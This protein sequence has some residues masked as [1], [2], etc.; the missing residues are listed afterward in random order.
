VKPATT[1]PSRITAKLT[2]CCCE[3]NRSTYSARNALYS[4]RPSHTILACVLV[5]ELVG[6]L[7]DHAVNSP[8]E[9][10]RESTRLPSDSPG[11]V[12]AFLYF[13]APILKIF[14]PQ[15]GHVPSLAGRQPSS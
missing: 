5:K 7:D 2:I 14:V 12:L 4:S 9:A 15:T 11:C 10:A 13:I 8:L 1:A 3:R 6:P